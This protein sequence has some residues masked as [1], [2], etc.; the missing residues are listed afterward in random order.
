MEEIIASEWQKVKHSNRVLSIKNTVNKLVALSSCSEEECRKALIGFLLGRDDTLFLNP[1]QVID[2]V[3]FRARY[4]MIE[5]MQEIYNLL[6][7]DYYV[8]NINM[9]RINCLFNGR[10]VVAEAIAEPSEPVVYE[11]L[12]PYLQANLQ[13]IMEIYLWWDRLPNKRQQRKA[14]LCNYLKQQAAPVKI[15][16]MVN[17]L[18]WAPFFMSREDFQEALRDTGCKHLTGDYCMLPPQTVADVI[19]W[20]QWAW[21][22]YAK[23]PELFM[24]KAMASYVKK[25]NSFS[26]EDIV[27]GLGILGFKVEKDRVEQ[28][29]LEKLECHR[30]SPYT[31]AKNSDNAFCFEADFR[32]MW[33]KTHELWSQRLKKR[34]KY[35]LEHRIL[36]RNTLE[37]TGQAIGVTRERVRQ[38]E[39]KILRKLRMPKSL[40]YIEPY[41][42][43]LLAL[44]NKHN[45]LELETL[46]LTVEDFPIFDFIFSAI[47]KPAGFIRV[48]QGIVL[49]EKAFQRIDSLI[50]E[51]VPDHGFIKLKDLQDDCDCRLP[52]P[53]YNK[54]LTGLW[55]MPEVDSGVFYYC[56]QKKLSKEEEI[57][58][59][60][61]RAGRP[62]HF[63]E[64]ETLAGKFALPFSL[65]GETRNILAAMQRSQQLKRVAPGTFA[66]KEWDISEHVFL[67]DLVYIVLEENGRPLSFE[68]IYMQVQQ[69]RNDN[70][71]KNSVYAYLN[72]HPDIIAVYTKQYILLEW[73]EN[74][75]LLL[76]NGID[77]Q[78]LNSLNGNYQGKVILDVFISHGNYFTL[79]RLS[80]AYWQ[81]GY[82]RLSRNVKAGLASRLVIVDTEGGL[83]L[84]SLQ[85]E[86]IS[87]L[88]RWGNNL[89]INEL[90]YLEFI[91][92]RVLRC[93]KKE[94]FDNYEEL[95]A[96]RLKEAEQYLNEQLELDEQTV[97]QNG[98]ELDESLRG[99]DALLDAGLI[100][101]FVRGKDF[102]Q[103]VNQGYHPQLIRHVLEERGIKVNW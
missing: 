91:N 69:R 34:E 92:D 63:T 25:H 22:E 80:E 64:V 6:A 89:A 42:Q 102:E 13:D 68:Q 100:N 17:A 66:W 60:V 70:I 88:K 90:F 57:S 103:V 36:G 47:I 4:Q 54:L 96:Y 45:Y 21:N 71:S 46:A 2:L 101:G 58:L 43:W 19:S 44:I 99:L 51:L 7:N 49:V 1:N 78:E 73:L 65:E 98:D 94:Q 28:I 32:V 83:H 85:W 31:W 26:S 50:K 48:Y 95:P 75:E 59:V 14:S 53:I 79:Y 9:E 86:I 39:K 29:L 55:G 23:S 41:Y 16:D 76:T 11:T 10:K 8:T 61:Y 62:L 3:E 67:R 12:H 52:P 20:K 74:E 40:I 93:L 81:S 15:H 56:R 77:P 72:S 82:I 18:N 27:W 24:E 35:I 33:A 84:G 87:G 37:E 97:L 30:D 38:I 5:D